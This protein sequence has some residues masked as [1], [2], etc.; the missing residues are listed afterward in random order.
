MF[1]EGEKR[2]IKKHT[3]KSLKELYNRKGTNMKP[4]K[5]RPAKRTDNP[6]IGKLLNLKYR[7]NDTAKAENGWSDDMSSDKRYVQSLIND[8]RKHK[9]TKIAPEDAH[10]CNGLW[11]KYA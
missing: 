9:F 3:E 5:K 7:I 10:C 8:I 11:K 4:T 1:T 2:W 6:I